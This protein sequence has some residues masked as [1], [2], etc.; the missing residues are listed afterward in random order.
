LQ[1]IILNT[2]LVIFGV[3]QINRLY[4]EPRLHFIKHI[5]ADC[6]L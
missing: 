1:K 2:K 5:S 6:V 4:N 3:E